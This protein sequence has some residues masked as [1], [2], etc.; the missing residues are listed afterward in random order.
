MQA[1]M[2]IAHAPPGSV[3]GVRPAPTKNLIR[4]FVS[5]RIRRYQERLFPHA[6]RIHPAATEITHVLQ[7]FGKDEVW[8]FTAPRARRIRLGEIEGDLYGF[9]APLLR[10]KCTLGGV[11]VG[12]PQDLAL[13]RS[14]WKK[15]EGKEYDYLD[16]LDFLLYEALRY[17][18]ATTPIFSGLLG[19]GRE[20]YVC[21]TMIAGAFRLYCREK[22][23][24]KVLPSVPVELTTPAHFFLS[25][26][27]FA[28][29]LLYN[30]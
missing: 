30:L 13:L 27:D 19:L 21:S 26:A 5:W 16:L 23:I 8:E 11:Q 18:R 14:A 9:A 22:R 7:Y 1:G 3:I 25:P 2:I 10:E 29:S 17:P 6:A 28:V 20:R 15:V 24:P 12:A 4:K